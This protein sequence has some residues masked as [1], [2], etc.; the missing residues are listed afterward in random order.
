M[1]KLDVPVVL[2]L[3]HLVSTTPSGIAAAWLD[4]LT[5]PSQ[6]LCWFETAAACR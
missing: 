1:T 5:V 3:G 6:T 4:Q 2:L